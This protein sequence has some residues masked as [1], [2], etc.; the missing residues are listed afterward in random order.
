MN[1]HINRPR[2]TGLNKR[3]GQCPS[4]R[5]R[6]TLLGRGWGILDGKLYCPTH[7]AARQAALK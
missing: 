2:I 5:Q 4:C 7:C 1:V 3:R 6:R